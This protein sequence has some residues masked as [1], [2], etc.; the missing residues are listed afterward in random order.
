M[1]QAFRVLS[2]SLLCFGLLG[3]GY[4]AHVEATDTAK[5]EIDA[6]KQ[7]YP[8]ETQRPV[9]PRVNC[10][11]DARMK[12]ARVKAEYGHRHLDLDELLR[13]KA[14]L[15]AEQYDARKMTEAQYRL[16]KAQAVT[17][18]KSEVMKRNNGA[19]IAEAAS[20]PVTCTTV[21]N[22]VTCF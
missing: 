2:G 5:A 20:S 12:A 17:D 7:L 8:N 3:C 11:L 6:C 16:E 18:Y 22:T 9:T 13:A 4:A 10:I 21:G 19:A 15:L 1:F 14:L